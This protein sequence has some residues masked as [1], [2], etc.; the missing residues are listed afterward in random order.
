MDMSGAV[1]RT[2]LAILLLAAPTFANACQ[3]ITPINVHEMRAA[4]HAIVVRV[5]GTGVPPA[6]SPMFGIANVKVIDRLR[7]DAVP[8]RLRYWPGF[9]CPM[10][11]EAVT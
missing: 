4:K 9:C 7:G 3:C 11:I 8:M 6:P 2:G 5:I 1:S 10:R